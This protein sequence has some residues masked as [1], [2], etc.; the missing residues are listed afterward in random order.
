MYAN[1]F[2]SVHVESVGRL[3]L[4]QLKVTVFSAG[5]GVPEP[6]VTDSICWSLVVA[7]PAEPA[8]L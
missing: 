3:A 5:F 2:G 7:A 6:L 4:H 8:R 1:E